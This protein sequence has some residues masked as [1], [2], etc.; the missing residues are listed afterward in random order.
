MDFL[1]YSRDLAKEITD[2]KQLGVFLEEAEELAHR[3]K[4]YQLTVVRLKG[5]DLSHV[6][7]LFSR[8][9]SKGQSMT[10]DQLVSA[11]TYQ[12]SGESLADRIG[13]IREDLGSVGYGQV[14][15]ITVFRATL[16]VA[17]EEE[18]LD[19]RWDILARRVQGRLEKAVEDTDRAIQ[20]A[21]AFLRDQVGVPMARLIPYQHQV[22]LL[23]AFF[24]YLPTPSEQQRRM[25]EEWFWGTSWSGFFAGANSTQIK[26]S[27]QDMQRFAQG[28][29]RTPWHP[30]PARPF[31]ER[32]DLRSARVRAFILWELR[33]FNVRLA[34]DGSKIDAVG[35]LARSDAEAYRHVVNNIPAVSHPANRMILPTPPGTSVRTALLNLPEADQSIVAASHGIPPEALDRLQ[36]GDG[37]GFVKER[38]DALANWERKFMV[39]MHIEPSPDRSSDSDIDT[40]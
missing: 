35:L 38:A 7:D 14:S 30:Q 8:L 24:H 33:R 40:E 5:G 16:A 22:I 34:P 25:L 6:V 21:A 36:V 20:L 1:A 3:L 18:V 11:L 27:L 15:P 39:A 31:P 32:F 9:N 4:S 13:L 10:P 23:T 37:Q 26:D 12:P 2:T 19:A 28:R 17:G 29:I